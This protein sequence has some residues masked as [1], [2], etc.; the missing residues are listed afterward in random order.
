[1]LQVHLSRLDS[2]TAINK[3]TYF[4]KTTEY[5]IAF[6]KMSSLNDFVYPSTVTVI[7]INDNYNL[8]S[9]NPS[10]PLPAG[11]QSL[12]VSGNNNK[13]NGSG[14]LAP[15]TGLTYPLPAT[16]TSIDFGINNWTQAQVNAVLV[17]LDGL[18]FNAG[19]KTLNIKQYIAG[20]TPS[21]AGLTAKSSL[22]SKGW[23]VTTD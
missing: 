19:A 21:G 9:F 13:P 8:T 14:I 6:T 20:S 15:I 3:S 12:S 17:Y 18:T 11:L 5:D 2:V 1:V 7:S 23:T 22:Q 16:I 10:T 4:S